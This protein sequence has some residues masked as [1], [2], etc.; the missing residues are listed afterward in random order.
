MTASLSGA[1][2]FAHDLARLARFYEA[3]LGLE[4]NEFSADF[5]AYHAGG[6]QFML[7][8][9]PPH[10]AASFSIATPPEIREEAAI[11]LTFTVASLDAARKMAAEHGG[12]LSGMAWEGDQWRFA[13]GHDPEGNV[14]QLRE[15][16]T[17]KA[18]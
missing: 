12:D 7:H 3:L 10:I 5:R 13:N 17:A 11:R 14:F 15:A 1:L 8:A 16:R 18:D 6:A 2:I 9:I 4:A